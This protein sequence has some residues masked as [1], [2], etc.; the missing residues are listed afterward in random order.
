MNAKAFSKSLERARKRAEERHL[1]AAIAAYQRIIRK[2]GD[3]A[4][5]NLRA[6]SVTA[7]ATPWQPPPDGLLYD[8]STVS[9]F[10]E[11]ALS[12]TH[13]RIVASVVGAPLEQIGIAW[14]ISHP[15]TTAL[16]EQ[17][18]KRT[19]QQLG[20]AVQPVLREAVQQAYTEGLSVRDAGAL[21][22]SKIDEA[23]VWQAEMLARTDLNGLSNGG[24]V[25]AAKMAGIETKTWLSAS[26]GQVASGSCGRVGAVGPDR[27]AVPG[28][29]GVARL[30]R[31]PRRLGRERREL[32]MLRICSASPRSLL[33][34]TKERP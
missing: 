27:P 32:P 4:A 3:L 13:K 7:A 1:E 18:A 11:R 6:Q 31:R 25:I 33:P 28:R 14:D 15:L 22:R 9:P 8:A 2:V 26:D 29:R 19:G 30:P 21:I 24:S 17:S 12:T 5:S 23:S 20:E 34:P 10:A 16:L